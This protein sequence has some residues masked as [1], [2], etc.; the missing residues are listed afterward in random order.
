LFVLKQFSSGGA[1]LSSS[2]KRLRS[3][4]STTGERCYVEP[5][6]KEAL[7]EGENRYG[8]E[9]SHAHESGGPSGAPSATSHWPAS[10]TSTADTA[11]MPDPNY[12]DIGTGVNA[13]VRAKQEFIVFL[14]QG[15]QTTCWNASWQGRE[16]A[17]RALKLC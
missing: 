8:F 15:F 11:P 17:D 4:W 7:R 6:L 16:A 12:G 3:V 5:G 9:L 13:P 1:D 10:S 2:L 14:P